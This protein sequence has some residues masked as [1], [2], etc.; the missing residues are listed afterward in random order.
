MIAG[1]GVLEVQHSERA[2][3]IAIFKTLKVDLERGG[4]AG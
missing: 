1:A 2:G 4:S 3:D